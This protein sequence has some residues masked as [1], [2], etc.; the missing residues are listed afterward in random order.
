MMQD[1]FYEVSISLYYKDKKASPKIGMVDIIFTPNDKIKFSDLR[2]YLTKKLKK[3]ASKKMTKEM[4]K[5]DKLM[6]RKGHKWETSENFYKTILLIIK[7]KK[8]VIVLDPR[9]EGWINSYGCK[10]EGK[11]HYIKIWRRDLVLTAF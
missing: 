8:G 11:N 1:K 5:F 6:S 4:N 10:I 7:D 2:K 9:F 3:K